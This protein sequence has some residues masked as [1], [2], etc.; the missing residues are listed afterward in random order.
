MDLRSLL[1][2]SFMAEIGTD[3]DKMC[4]LLLANDYVDWEPTPGLL[5]YLAC[6]AKHIGTSMR[7]PK[8]GHSVPEPWISDVDLQIIR[9]RCV[10]LFWCAYLLLEYLTESR[11]GALMM[12]LFGK[13]HGEELEELEALRL[14]IQIAAV[15]LL[16][17]YI[18]VCSFI[19]SLPP[20]LF[21]IRRSKMG[22]R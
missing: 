1:S 21:Q 16:N 10:Y 7:A 15:T 19:D 12:D 9:T 14:D 3:I 17:N 20:R 4:Q 5:N 8:E 2:L 11:E 22:E 6:L 13:C 18:A